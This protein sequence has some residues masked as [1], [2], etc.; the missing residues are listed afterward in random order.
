MRTPDSP[1]NYNAF[2]D[3]QRRQNEKRQQFR[4]VAWLKDN[5]SS[6]DSDRQVAERVAKQTGGAPAR[7]D[8]VEANRDLFRE[9]DN[10]AWVEKIGKEAP[11]TLASMG[12]PGVGPR[13]R[14]DAEALAIIEKNLRNVGDVSNRFGGRAS[15]LGV[16]LASASPSASEAKKDKQ[17]VV[18]PDVP[19]GAG[20]SAD[21]VPPTVHAKEVLSSS[22]STERSSQSLVL[23]G[24]GAQKGVS[25]NVVGGDGV[26]SAHPTSAAAPHADALGQGA[27][28]T[29]SAEQEQSS[30]NIAGAPEA[31]SIHAD[32]SAGGDA[33]PAVVSDTSSPQRGVETDTSGSL[34][35][36]PPEAAG[37]SVLVP[38]TA[39][40]SEN[41]NT[42]AAAVSERNTPLTPLQNFLVVPRAFLSAAPAFTSGLTGLVGVTAGYLGA[43]DVAQWFLRQSAKG[44]AVTELT[45]GPSGGR[46]G[47]VVQD[48]SRG[49]GTALPGAVATVATGGTAAPLA[50][51]AA[52]LIPGMIAAAGN[53]A[54]EAVERGRTYGEALSYAMRNATIGLLTSKIPAGH[55]FGKSGQDGGLLNK[56]IQDFIK[57][58]PG[59]VANTVLQKYNSY[60]TL[61]S[62][63]PIGQFFSE[64]P[65]QVAED[66]L[67]KIL[68]VSMEQSWKQ[69]NPADSP[70]D[71]NFLEQIEKSRSAQKEVFSK[72]SSVV[73]EY[74]KNIKDVKSLEKAIES[75]TYRTEAEYIYIES[76]D[77]V[78]FFEESGSNPREVANRLGV[79][80]RQYNAIVSAGA[81]F[82][83]STGVI[84]A[85]FA[86]TKSGEGL[87]PKMRFDPG[88]MT[89]AEAQ[90]INRAAMRVIS[91]LAEQ[92]F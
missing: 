51:G 46:F 30:T 76:G 59:E 54:T 90:A 50:L 11:I 56:I 31:A 8:I 25:G 23:T 70:V 75:F 18:L 68:S 83:F 3:S 61:N 78:S 87:L 79:S 28:A 85:R 1:E 17:E 27:T 16:Q 35:P 26:A 49:F 33:G 22:P 86:G 44:R 9:A 92:G 15:G 36:A 65:V 77:F 19:Q 6:P 62:D 14:S 53:D 73:G 72:L 4:V 52:T 7:E 34:A 42:S 74:R 55:F 84:L 29:A 32:L 10:R 58:A 67:K 24:E 21:G 64:L 13:S 37:S 43:E 82:R 69:E 91:R 2:K 60:S 88:R 71:G 80:E 66:L 12:D 20:A 39:A 48:A 89:L 47:E 63:K 81:D 45:A 40:N 5:D 57:E 41:S 38:G